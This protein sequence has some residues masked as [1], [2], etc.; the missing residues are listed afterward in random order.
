MRRLRLLAADVAHLEDAAPRVATP[1]E[2]DTTIA[3]SPMIEVEDAA[4]E[5]TTTT[6]MKTEAAVEEVGIIIITITTTTMTT[7]ITKAVVVVTKRRAVDRRGGQALP[8]G[9][10]LS[11]LIRSDPETMT[12]NGPCN[13]APWRPFCRVA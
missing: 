12:R 6:T 11:C 4:E 9:M 3:K 7:T 5:V 1:Q 8:L 10:K 2:D 13:V